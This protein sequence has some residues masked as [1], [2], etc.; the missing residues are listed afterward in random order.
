MEGALQRHRENGD[1]NAA[2]KLKACYTYR[3][4]DLSEFGKTLFQ[5]FSQSYNFRH[6]RKGTLWEGRFQS[7]PVGGAIN[8]LGA[9]AAYIDPSVDGLSNAPPRRAPPPILHRQPWPAEVRTA[10]GIGSPATA[11][12]ARRPRN[13]VSAVR[14]AR[15]RRGWACIRMPT[16]PGNAAMGVPRE[17]HLRARCRPQRSKR[18]TAVIPRGTAP[19]ARAQARACPPMRVPVPS[20]TLE[21]VLP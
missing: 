12:K 8:A 21:P 16:K 2:A 17:G 4:Y 11:P 3:M 15:G 19:Q 13:G 9:L 18:P 10:G 5:R 1:E 7:L 14:P 20:C 6:G